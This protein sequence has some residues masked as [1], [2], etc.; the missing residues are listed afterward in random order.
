[1]CDNLLLLLLFLND[2]V[3]VFGENRMLFEGQE[4]SLVKLHGVGFIRYDFGDGMKVR[5]WHD[6]WQGK[7]TLKE[8][9]RVIKL[10][11]PSNYLE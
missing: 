5:F 8:R 2:N 11:T 7:T 4:L 3:T 9:C 10:I 6:L 1:M